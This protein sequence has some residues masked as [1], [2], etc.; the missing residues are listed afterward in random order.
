MEPITS[1]GKTGL[2]F[3][4]D[5]SGIHLPVPSEL[6]FAAY[7]MPASKSLEFNLDFGNPTAIAKVW[8]DN[9]VLKEVEKKKKINY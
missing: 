2:I 9:G 3:V 5:E 7:N 1:D 6:N 4:D 8:H